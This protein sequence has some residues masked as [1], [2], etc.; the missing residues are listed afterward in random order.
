[1]LIAEEMDIAVTV[2][3]MRDVT[4]GIF[5]NENAIPHEYILILKMT[6]FKNKRKYWKAYGLTKQE[7]L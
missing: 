2:I 7:K 5:E 3:A 6:K 4:K 1:M